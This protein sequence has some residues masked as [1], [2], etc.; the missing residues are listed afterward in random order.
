MLEQGKGTPIFLTLTKDW[1]GSARILSSGNDRC[2]LGGLRSWLI[3]GFINEHL[4]LELNFMTFALLASELVWLHKHLLVGKA[5]ADLML[6]VDGNGDG[7]IDFKA[8][9]ILRVHYFRWWLHSG[10][11][12]MMQTLAPKIVSKAYFSNLSLLPKLDTRS[13]WRWWEDRVV[14]SLLG[15]QTNHYCASDKTGTKWPLK[16][17]YWGDLDNMS[18]TLCCSVVIPFSA[19]SKA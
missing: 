6:E 5:L 14:A 8:G 19:Q 13:S 15:A 7:F 2:L 16:K 18:D 3:F 10:M 11:S 4:R 12:E 9:W 17:G 1:P